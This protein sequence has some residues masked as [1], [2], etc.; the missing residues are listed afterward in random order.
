MCISFFCEEKC[1]FVLF[2]SCQSSTGSMC[3]C[4]LKS[5]KWTNSSL[6]KGSIIKIEFIPEVKLNFSEYMFLLASW[7]IIGTYDVY[8]K[9]GIWV[10]KIGELFHKHVTRTEEEDC[11]SCSSISLTTWEM[12]KCAIILSVRKFLTL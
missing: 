12:R 3:Y 8:Y 7:L 6:K 4:W 5:F 9:N 11:H 10:Y 2:S 1:L